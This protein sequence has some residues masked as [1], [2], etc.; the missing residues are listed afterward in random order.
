MTQDADTRIIS[1]EELEAHHEKEMQV[2]DD[3]GSSSGL[4]LEPPPEYRE[5]LPTGSTSDLG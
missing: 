3:I 2:R 1:K 4:L 5:I